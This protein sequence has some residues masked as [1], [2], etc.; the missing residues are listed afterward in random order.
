MLKYP[1]KSTR[2]ACDGNDVVDFNQIRIHINVDVGKARAD[3]SEHWD[4]SM[5]VLNTTAQD[6]VGGHYVSLWEVKWLHQNFG[7]HTKGNRAAISNIWNLDRHIG[8]WEVRVTL[9]GLESGNEFDF[10]CLFEKV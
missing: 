9:K 3:P 5:K 10:V 4:M 6:I 7:P 8:L 1:D 2:L